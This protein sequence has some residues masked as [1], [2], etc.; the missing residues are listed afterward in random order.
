MKALLLVI[1][2]IVLA[3]DT[4]AQD[5]QC[6]RE[7]AAMVETIRTYARSAAGVLGQQGLSE[8]VL[9]AMAQTLR[10]LFIPERSCSIAYADQPIPI[11]LGQTISQPYVVALMTQLAEV[12]PDHVVLEVGTGSGYQAAILA[13]LAQKV[14]TIEIIPQ[15]AETAAK[16]LRD[17]AYDNASVRLGDGYNGWPECGPFD[18]IV[19]TAALGEP[20][21][22][23]IEQLKVGGRLVMPVGPAYTTQQLTVV[24]KVALGKTT[25]RAV[26]LVRFVPFMRSQN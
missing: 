26:A 20:P 17:L 7:R 6:V 16:T 5:A 14:C 13:R 21:P 2:M 11:G 23:L 25:T 15:L 19:V 3:R 9:E 4:S 1:A 18:A 10:H 22:P 24:E 8:R 12:A